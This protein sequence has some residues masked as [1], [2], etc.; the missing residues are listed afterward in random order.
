MRGLQRKPSAAL[1]NP[2]LVRT[3]LFIVFTDP[4]RY[5]KAHRSQSLMEMHQEKVAK[6]KEKAKQAVRRTVVVG[7]SCGVFVLFVLSLFCYLLFCSA[8][9]CC[10]FD[11]LGLDSNVQVA[12][13]TCPL[14]PGTET[15]TSTL[16][17]RPTRDCLRVRSSK[18][19]LICRLDSA[20]EGS[21]GQTIKY[22]KKKENKTE[23]CLLAQPTCCYSLLVFHSTTTV[24][25]LERWCVHTAGGLHIHRSRATDV[26]AL[27]S[28]V[29]LAVLQRQVHMTECD[30]FARCEG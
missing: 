29:S 11:N 18:A 26:V 20:V 30:V 15:A 27:E 16:V 10:L 8:G 28:C 21:G 13:H 23:Y 19:A 24:Y 22:I 2:G 9:V 5:N 17:G 25:G 3:T 6:K 4:D 1:L 12:G 14:E 7:R